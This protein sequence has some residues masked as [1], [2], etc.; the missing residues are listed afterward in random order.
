MGEIETILHLL[1]E[2]NQLAL[3]MEL[4]AVLTKIDDFFSDEIRK[5]INGK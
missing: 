1:N 2:A 5:R 4:E 3:V